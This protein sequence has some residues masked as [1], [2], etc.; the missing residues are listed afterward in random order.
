M[1]RASMMASTRLSRGRPR[2]FPTSHRQIHPWQGHYDENVHPM[3]TS[4]TE[5]PHTTNGS[6]ALRNLDAQIYGLEAEVS[7]GFSTAET[8]L[9]LIDL[10]VLR[11]RTIG[12][13]ADYRRAERLANQLV[14]ETSSAESLLARARIHALFHRFPAALV[15]LD[16][17][18]DLSI[19]D[20]PT[21]EQERA[22][23]FQGLGRYDDALALRQQAVDRC[24]TFEGLAALAGLCAERGQ[25]ET[26][27]QLYVDSHLRYR[28]VSPFPLALLDF[29]F[30]HMWMHQGEWKEAQN[31]LQ[32][33]VQR[34]PAYAPAQGHLAEVEA[35]IGD[36]EN[37]LARLYPLASSSDDPDYASQLARILQ[38]LGRIEESRHWCRLAARTYS[39]LVIEYPEAFADHAADFWLGPGANPNK[40]LELARINFATRKTPRSYALLSRAFGA[41]ETL[42]SGIHD[43][44]CQRIESEEPKAVVHPRKGAE[45]WLRK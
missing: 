13:I 25:I 2:C 11:G 27:L 32:F 1:G 36:A 9:C 8:R 16:V 28:G 18:G 20:E 10:L 29:Q 40:A 7:S 24:A 31:L 33:A 5:R 15:D 35:E 39:E 14:G 43:I 38:D 34:L 42:R 22:A 23:I 45:P 37:A 30:G 44:G 21:V 41:N 17:A 3:L 6:I 12:R 19:I 26:A 4:S